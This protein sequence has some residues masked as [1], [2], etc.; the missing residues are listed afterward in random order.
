MTSK[1]PLLAGWTK[2]QF[3]ALIGRSERTLDRWHE[4]R[5]GP[6]RI[7]VGSMI[8][9]PAKTYENWVES[10]TAKLEEDSQ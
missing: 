9:Y 1:E 5:I 2:A 6:P 7:K 10:E 8:F 4:L 3:A